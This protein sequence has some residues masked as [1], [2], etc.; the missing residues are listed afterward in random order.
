M[1]YLIKN[2]STTYSI[3]TNKLFDLPQDETYAIVD[4]KFIINGIIFA[5]IFSTPRDINSETLQHNLS[6]TIDSIYDTNYKEILQQNK[7]KFI[8]TA[9]QYKPDKSK[10]VLYGT[11]YLNILN[12]TIEYSRLLS[13]SPWHHYE[14]LNYHTGKFEEYIKKEDAIDK[15]KEYV[16]EFLIEYKPTIVKEFSTKKEFIEYIK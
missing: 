14:I 6:S 1:I 10:D 15:L 9:I 11:S 3:V 5:N 4:N 16:N 13:D 7:N 2:L 8:I 12:N